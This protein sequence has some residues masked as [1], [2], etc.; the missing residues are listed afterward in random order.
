[1]I[2]S[3]KLIK[4]S[5]GDTVISTVKAHENDNFITLTEPI[6]MIRISQQNPLSGKMYE[7]VSFGPWE[8]MAK[9]QLFNIRKKDVLTISDPR[10]DM[11]KYY[12]TLKVRL[13]EEIE[14]DKQLTKQS[15]QALKEDIKQLPGT[16]NKQKISNLAKILDEIENMKEEYL[17]E[18]ISGESLNKKKPTVH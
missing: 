8:P 16:D 18:E 1:M 17:D 13:K 14:L 3:V 11:I 6:K 7:N 5:N 9:T 2:M 12:E 15:E 10:P 4:L